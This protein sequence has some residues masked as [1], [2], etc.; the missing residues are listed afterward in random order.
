[1]PS[2]A[3]SPMIEPTKDW[4]VSVCTP[5]TGTLISRFTNDI[6]L[7]RNVVSNT[8][9]S[10]GK[11]AMTLVFL[12]GVMFVAPGTPRGDAKPV[13]MYEKGVYLGKPDTAP[14]DA[15]K[16]PYLGPWRN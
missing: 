10:L 3:K 11:D 1:M 5:R 2:L 7:L 8:L 14:S 16:T 13:L 12:V 9:T 4:P 6:A 15:K